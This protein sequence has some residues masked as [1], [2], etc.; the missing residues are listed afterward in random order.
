MISAHFSSLALALLGTTIWNMGLVGAVPLL[1]ATTGFSK[2]SESTFDHEMVLTD[3]LTFHWNDV[4][5]NTVE[6]R[7]IHTAP[8]VD[9]APS[10]LG[11]GIYDTFANTDPVTDS[12]PFMIGSD[13]VIGLVDAG[14]V[15][16]Y[17]LT[18]KTVA[19][20]TPATQTLASGILKQ[21]DSD[22]G[23]V[24]T[25][26]SFEKLLEEADAEEVSIRHKGTNVFLWAVGP[27]GQTALG[28]HEG[29]G[30]FTLDLAVVSQKAGGAG[31]D[32]GA[33]TSDSNTSPVVLAEC[34][35]NLEGATHSIALTPDVTLHYG[36]GEETLTGILVY[37]GEGWIGHAFSADGKMV[38]STAIIGKPDE[39]TVE[40]YSLG[41]QSVSGVVSAPDQSPLLAEGTSIKQENGVTTL[42]FV[43]LLKDGNTEWIQKTGLNTFLFA[44]GVDN[45]FPAY[46]KE[47]E[48]YRI[49][50]ETCTAEALATKTKMGA[51]AAHGV[52]ATLAWAI[53]SPFA[54]TV[55]WFRTLVPSS[56]IYI[57]V[58]SNVLSFFFTL[59]AVIVAI[60]ALSVQTNPNHFSNPHHWVGLILLIGI[61][62]QVMN[63]F[64]R[65]PVEKRDPY[66]ASHYDMENSW[67]KL[68]NSPRQLWYLTHRL[69][70]VSML[71][72]AIY[73]IQS[74]L[75]LFA[76]DFAVT[77]IAPWYWGYVGLFAACLVSLKFWIMYEEYKARRNMETMHIDHRSAS[78]SSA[79][80]LSHTDSELMPVSYGDVSS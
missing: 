80:G 22:D 15:E 26:M 72:M 46:H 47:R 55:A 60:S 29:V 10:W 64:L 36:V 28:K 5:G 42:R 75:R 7:L 9:Q 31:G 56:W 41:D 12:T 37:Q 11:F 34:E 30:A 69:M 48:S 14:T 52:F 17:S 70:A 76:R 6:G 43:H 78:G 3:S 66:A 13:A 2:S 71:G 4:S 74:G 58:F 35:S 51:F 33:S 16:K 61:T 23:T 8:S 24:T 65:P 21:H 73:Q 19:D 79:G 27:P 45:K 62:F 40:L 68:P 39:G 50:L 20:V 38:G 59:I 77:S 49:D 57:H 63:G 53:C 32:D 18:G 25:V 44:L 67:I 54:M 1:D